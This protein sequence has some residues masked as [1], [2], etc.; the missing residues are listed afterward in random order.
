M[1]TK[2]I[3]SRKALLYI[4]LC[5]DRRNI[6]PGFSYGYVSTIGSDYWGVC[7]NTLE[8]II[9]PLRTNL[10]EALETLER[11]GE[12]GL[13]DLEPSRNFRI[14]KHD[15]KRLLRLIQSLM[16]ESSGSETCRAILSR[17]IGWDAARI[18]SDFRSN[19][20][21]ITMHLIET[22]C[23]A[24]DISLGKL[25]RRYFEIYGNT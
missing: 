3:F 5:Y 19:A 23:N 6:T 14:I 2:S 4:L 11:K 10:Y 8:D 18:G 21:S 9:Y 13:M 12:E 15:R 17:R 22:Y 1:N 16:H 25:F 7:L 24:A 20:K